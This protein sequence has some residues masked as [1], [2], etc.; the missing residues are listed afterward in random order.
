MWPASNKAFVPASEPRIPIYVWRD[1]ALALRTGLH[2]QS[3]F[4]PGLAAARKCLRLFTSDP[5]AKL[6]C[7][8]AGVLGILRTSL[9]GR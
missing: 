1:V 9:I 8:P 7:H 2:K 6:F 3:I 4:E 5:P